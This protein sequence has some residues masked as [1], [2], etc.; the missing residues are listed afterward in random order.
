MQSGHDAELKYRTLIESID[1]GFCIIE[2]IFDGERAVD[3]RFLEANAAFVKQTNLTDAIGKRMRDLIPT[4]EE[5][6]FEI[7]GRIATTGVPE[8]FENPA[9]ALGFYYEVLA[10][11]IG[12]PKQ[13][14]V[15][16][17]FRDV[18]DRRRA[19]QAQRA[20]EERAEALIRASSDAVYRMSPNWEEMRTLH[21]RQFI[22]DMS[23]PSVNWLDTYIPLD[24]R[25][26]IR[27]AIADAL[28]GKRLFELE[29]RVLRVDGSIGWTLSRAVPTFDAEGNIVEWVGLAS[30]ITARKNAQLALEQANA[31]LREA[32]E[33]KNGFLAVLSHE[34]RNPLAPIKNSI[35]VMNN[36]EPGSEQ[37]KRSLA[38]IGR[39]VDQLAR[40]VDDLLDL[41]RITQ[42]KIELQRELVDLNDI[43]RSTLDDYR[44]SFESAGIEIQLTTPAE[45]CIVNGDRNRLAQ[46][47][48]NLLQNA[49]KFTPTGGRV[50]VSVSADA[51]TREATIR[52]N[53]TG[54]GMTEETLAQLFEPFMQA[55]RTLD[56]SK[57]GLGL[58]LALVKRLVEL[59]GG[60]ASATSSGVGHGSDLVMHLPLAH[61]PSSEAQR[62]R[63]NKAVNRRR[64]LL[65][66]DNV[67]AADSLCE[68][69]QL[70]GHEV[71]VAYNG[72]DGI[73]KA[74]ALLPDFIICDVGLPVMDGY[75]VARTLRADER[76]QG[77]RLIALT[78]YARPDD[79]R[80]AVEAGFDRHLAK[81][82]ALE[83]L[84]AIL[85]E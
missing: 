2:V 36:T 41:T 70:A 44:R 39:Q 52:V 5:H 10:F 7:Y 26:R 65:I 25:P 38:V 22:A 24:E 20:S 40:L 49:A 54:A 66:E 60:R 28:D 77:A 34:L 72:P 55:D 8:R 62:R 76:L 59:H 63:E 35:Y 16:V 31:Q 12:T 43:V 29:H 21:G 82:P 69:L 45:K 18:S 42:N 64:V 37:A 71:N 67:D 23:E 84:E 68:L 11:R 58:G 46:A 1:D 57:G 51:Q 83:I 78:G 61:I 3:Y 33:R 80:R 17:L 14:H 74:R 32:D 13:H 81:P 73:A 4:H 79:L 15:A 50:R 30:D 9:D 75:E 27:A 19:E 48:G 47:I 6:W 53:D 56:R 85:S